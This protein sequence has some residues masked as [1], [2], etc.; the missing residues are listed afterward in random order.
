MQE[1]EYDAKKAHRT[2]DKVPFAITSVVVSIVGL[3]TVLAG[4]LVLITGP[5]LLAWQGYAWLRTGTWD[6]WPLTRGLA[7]LATE[8][9][10]ANG[11]FTSWLERPQD[12]VGLHKILAGAPCSLTLI[13]AGFLV[14][15]LGV[16]LTED[17]K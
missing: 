9:S 8:F 16:S 14:I 17:G 10:R 5:S 2:K 12:F 1:F 3:V 7:F 15:L 13:L 6:A 11:S 4:G